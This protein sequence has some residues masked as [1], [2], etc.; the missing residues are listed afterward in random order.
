MKHKAGFVNIIGLPNVGK[1]TFMNAI[2]GE[3][4]SIITPKAQTTRHR[5]LGIL[6]SED[7][8]IV[9][10]DTPGIIKPKYKMQETMM[11]YVNQA[12]TDADV[13]LLVTE[14]NEDALTAHIPEKITTTKRPVIHLINKI[15]LNEQDFVVS[16]L[17]KW[18]ERLPNAIHIPVSAI[19]NFNI[20]KVLIEILHKLPEHEAYYPKDELS[21]RNMRFFVSEI[22]REKI[23]LNYKQEIPYSCEVQIE[24]Y[25][26]KE[27]IV[28]IRAIIYVNRESQKSILIGK[29]GL[30]LKRVGTQARIDIE[31][32]IDSKVFLELFVK[33]SD[34]WRNN[35]KQLRS[36]GYGS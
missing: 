15:D 17:E 22:I 25:V 10:S 23:L 31:K 16:Q 24:E 29:G 9:F 32:F 13:L 1:S 8:Q 6:N 12:L 14:I 20:S 7:Y 28:H 19:K 18:T 3:K 11:D 34:N 26:E 33:V 27:N 35:P 5:I 36:F 30:A 4:L 21:D 2:L